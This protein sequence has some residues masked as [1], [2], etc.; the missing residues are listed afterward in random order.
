MGGEKRK[1]TL[2]NLRPPS[3][4]PPQ[5]DIRAGRSLAAAENPPPF[6]LD[7]KFSLGVTVV[8]SSQPADFP[9]RLYKRTYYIH[10]DP[11]EL[12]HSFWMPT[13]PRVEG[14]WKPHIARCPKRWL[15]WFLLPNQKEIRGL[16][17]FE[18]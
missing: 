2:K 11:H 13:S 10:S 7:G 3:L 14:F 4:Y 5:V 6:C 8:A 1:G 12:I 18:F 16:L 17:L 9:P 15:F